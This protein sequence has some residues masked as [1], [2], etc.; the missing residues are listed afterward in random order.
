MAWPIHYEWYVWMRCENIASGSCYVCSLLRRFPHTNIPHSRAALH[1]KTERSKLVRLYL[2]RQ[3]WFLVKTTSIWDRRI[4]FSP[5]RFQKYFES[6]LRFVFR[7]ISAYVE[8][9]FIEDCVFVFWTLYLVVNGV[10][11]CAT[12]LWVG[13]GKDGTVVEDTFSDLLQKRQV[14]YLELFRL[15]ET[16]HF[17]ML[18]S[19]LDFCVHYMQIVCAV[20]AFGMLPL[21]V[22]TLSGIMTSV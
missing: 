9:L 17:L 14:C 4:G 13:S 19:W 18:V 3:K 16:P 1:Q 21:I 8:W 6:V 10:L 2:G 15:M 11:Y 5:K 20:F 22:T 7:V 12:G